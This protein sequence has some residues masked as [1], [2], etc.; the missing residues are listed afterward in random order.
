MM[1]KGFTLVELVIVILILGILVAI[2]ASK[3]FNNA[4]EAADSSVMRTLNVVRAAIDMYQAENSGSFPGADGTEATLKGDLSPYLRRAFPTCTV[5]PVRNNQVQMTNASVPLAG[6]ANPPKSWKYSR[7][8]GQ[9]I[10]N[11]NQ[12]TASDPSVAYDEL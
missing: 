12:P 1:R 10:I 4:S 7:A 8:T 11:Y 5:G 2:A 3:V 9:F 6:G